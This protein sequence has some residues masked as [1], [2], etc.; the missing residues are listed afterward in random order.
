MRVMNQ[1]TKNQAGTV[2]ARSSGVVPEA[3]ALKSAI[4]ITCH[5]RTVESLFV[6]LRLACVH[7]SST[8]A[9]AQ[10]GTSSSE[11]SGSIRAGVF[12]GND[13]DAVGRDEP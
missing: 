12:D 13:E 9:T 11:S 7:S 4:Y 1:K 5:S 3:T 10:F 2:S 6:A 8:L